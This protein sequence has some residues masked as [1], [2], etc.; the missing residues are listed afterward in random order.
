MSC[1][2]SN[3]TGWAMMESLCSWNYVIAAHNFSVAPLRLNLYVDFLAV[4]IE[5]AGPHSRIYCLQI[6]LIACIL[7]QVLLF[8]SGNVKKKSIVISVWVHFSICSNNRGFLQKSTKPFVTQKKKQKSIKE[9]VK[10]NNEY[11]IVDNFW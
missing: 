4:A 7:A 3:K 2:S 9:I 1:S 11:K 6:I 8:C 5:M 10:N